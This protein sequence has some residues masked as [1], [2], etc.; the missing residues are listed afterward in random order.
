[1]ATRKRSANRVLLDAARGGRGAKAHGDRL[2]AQA[3]RFLAQLG[4]E[5]VELSLSLVGDREIRALN[6]VWRKQDTATDV[7]SFP[8]G[9]QPGPGP[10]L[11]GDLVVSL[12]TARRQAAE[13]DTALPEELSRYLAHGLL[14]LL[15]FDHHRRGEA[16]RMEAEERRLLG[17]DGMLTRSDEV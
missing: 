10:R 12:D 13:F 2:K 9:E 3:R 17:H 15:G 5:G 16:A 7:L 11:L 1:M 14:H 6:R 4:L 8:G